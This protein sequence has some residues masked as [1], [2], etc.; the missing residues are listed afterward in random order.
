LLLGRRDNK[1]T[2]NTP[3][4]K[5][6]GLEAVKKFRHKEGLKDDP[7]KNEDGREKRKRSEEN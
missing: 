1:R 4:K 5:G 7:N 6:K 2:Y 3:P